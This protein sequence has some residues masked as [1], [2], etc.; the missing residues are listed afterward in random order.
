MCI[1]LDH[2]LNSHREKLAELLD[3]PALARIMEIQK[4]A[5]DDS[6]SEG[7]EEE[8]EEEEEEEEEEEVQDAA[9]KAAEAA[10]RVIIS[11]D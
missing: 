3:G 8:G 6:D 2:P 7:E 10:E 11:Y 5:R 1:S 9:A 4:G